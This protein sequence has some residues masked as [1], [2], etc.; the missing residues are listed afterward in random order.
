MAGMSE[1]AREMKVLCIRDQTWDL[2]RFCRV[3]LYPD[4]VRTAID[5]QKNI[6]LYTC[7]SCRFIQSSYCVRIVGQQVKLYAAL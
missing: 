3:R 1:N 5:L 6:K 2:N 4:A 7:L